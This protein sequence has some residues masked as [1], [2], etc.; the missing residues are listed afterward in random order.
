MWKATPHASPSS[1]ERAGERRAPVH[2]PTKAMS[3]RPSTMAV[4][5]SPCPGHLAIRAPVRPAS[6]PACLPGPSLCPNQGRTAFMAETQAI[7]NTQPAYPPAR[8]MPNTRQIRARM[9]G[10][11][12]GKCAVGPVGRAKGSANRPVSTRDTAMASISQRVLGST[13]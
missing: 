11:T 9:P 12:G 5:A 1:S 8:P 3:S 4:S 10:R 2:R 7:L 6:T 13:Y